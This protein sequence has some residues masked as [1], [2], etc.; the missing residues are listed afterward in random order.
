MSV[1]L[2]TQIVFVW[3]VILLVLT[4]RGIVPR[5]KTDVLITIV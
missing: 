5:Y 3:G 1:S 2:T 4:V